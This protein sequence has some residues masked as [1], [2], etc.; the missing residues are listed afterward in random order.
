MYFVGLDVHQSRSSVEI[1]DCNGKLFS[2]TEGPTRMYHGDEVD[3]E[4]YDA[5]DIAQKS[6][7]SRILGLRFSMCITTVIHNDRPVLPFRLSHL[8]RS[9]L[10]ATD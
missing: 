7:S 8:R 4:E 1:L 2:R 3:Y 6:S 9:D 10:P 5:A